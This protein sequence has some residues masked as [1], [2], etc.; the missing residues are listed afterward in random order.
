MLV[1]FSK[2]LI[3]KHTPGSNISMIPCHKNDAHHNTLEHTNIY[4]VMMRCCRGQPQPQH[5][6]TSECNC[7]GGLDWK[8]HGSCCCWE[9][10]RWMKL[11][12]VGR[13]VKV[14][15]QVSGGKWD[16]VGGNS[17]WL[18]FIWSMIIWWHAYRRKSTVRWDAPPQF[19]FLEF[20]RMS[21]GTS[22]NT[23]TTCITSGE[24]GNH[25]HNDRHNFLS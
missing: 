13:V 17:S 16:K 3:H 24:R 14:I 20:A 11:F 12:F 1:I 19:R 21:T 7:T 25:A 10:M 2:T 18:V 6:T 8:N 4:G 23:S 15:A 5:H 9:W 22:T